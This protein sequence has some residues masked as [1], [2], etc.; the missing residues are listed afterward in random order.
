VAKASSPGE[1]LADESSPG[2]RGVGQSFGRGPT[3]DPPIP[4]RRA[5]PS[6]ES[7]FE[8][9]ASQR[10]AGRSVTAPRVG[11]PP[12]TDIPGAGRAGGGSSK[13]AAAAEPVGEG[14]TTPPPVRRSDPSGSPEALTSSGRHP[15]VRPGA[16]PTVTGENAGAAHASGSNVAVPLPGQRL[17]AE[18]HFRNALNMLKAGAF[19]RAAEELESAL[20]ER[21]GS[22]IYRA[23]LAWARFRVSPATAEAQK[24]V[25]Q[26]LTDDTAAM[27]TATLYLGH[28]LTAEG[29]DERALAYYQQCLMANSRNVEALRRVRLHRMRTDK[30]KEGLFERLFSK[31]TR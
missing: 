12:T 16:R 23:H 6:S 1:P 2:G 13:E 9:S 26:G 22:T 24:A 15:V 28:I 21:P 17:P 3:T 19:D 5:G 14:E 31:K 20:E 8:R 25:L 30:R 11:Q 27:E 29:D 10:S 4:G 18:Q 7:G